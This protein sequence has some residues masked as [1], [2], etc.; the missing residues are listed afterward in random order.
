[1]IKDG[2]MFLVTGFTGAKAAR[3]KEAYIAAFNWMAE[4]L[5][6]PSS[7]PGPVA[8]EARGLAL[9]YFGRCRQAVTAAGGKPP[10][11]DHAAEQRIADQMAA[12][13]VTGRRWLLAFGADGQPQLSAVPAGAVVVDP[14]DGQRLAELLRL[15]VPTAEVPGVMSACLDRLAPLAART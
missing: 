8:A 13:L 15:H 9:D 10:R 14:T 11:W 3:V 4:Q 7:I 2:F 12:L 1:M 6:A 5:A